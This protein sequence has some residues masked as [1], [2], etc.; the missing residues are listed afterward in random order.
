MHRECEG[1]Q[2]L[3]NPEHTEVSI[4]QL[5]KQRFVVVDICHAWLISQGLLMSAPVS[6]SRSMPIVAM[7]G[8]ALD[9]ARLK[10]ERG[11]RSPCH[12]QTVGVGVIRWRAVAC[13]HRTVYS[14]RRQYL[15]R[16]VTTPKG[17]TEDGPGVCAAL[18]GWRV[19]AFFEA[20]SVYHEVRRIVKLFLSHIETKLY[21]CP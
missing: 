20:I 3:F 10:G 6:S 8:C 17:E 2:I 12:Q 19:L 14:L 13:F 15:S 9:D 16:G 1:Y 7:F 4:T 21:F 11:M 18:R 5:C